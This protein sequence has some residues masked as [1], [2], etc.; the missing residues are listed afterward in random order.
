MGREVKLSRIETVLG[1]LS[2][3]VDKEIASREF[4][5]VTVLYA[6]GELNLGDLIADTSAE[7]FGSVDDVVSELEN[8]LP[9][10][11]VGEPFQSEGE[12]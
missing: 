8:V 6:N 3:P 5:D 11:A 12:G 9:R 4:D 7:Q 1:E 10:D 2:Y